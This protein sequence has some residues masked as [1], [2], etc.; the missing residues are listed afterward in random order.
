MEAEKQ[1]NEIGG[2]TPIF[3]RSHGQRVADYAH[4]LADCVSI[5]ANEFAEKAWVSPSTARHHLNNLYDQGVAGRFQAGRE[6]RYWSFSTGLRPDLGLNGNV[7]AI[8][9]RITEGDVERAIMQPGGIVGK[10]LASIIEREVEQ[11]ELVYRL[12][13]QLEFTETV[14]R[15]FLHKLWGPAYEN[16]LDHV[17]IHP[18]NMKLIVF[19]KNS[20]VS[21]AEM[22]KEYASSIVDFDGQVTFEDKRPADINIETGDFKDRKSDA[23]IEASFK[24]RFNA[25][26]QNIKPVF[27]P[28]WNMKVKSRNKT[29]FQLLAIDGLAGKPLE[30]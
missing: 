3:N 6:Q 13:I 1:N 2:L 9:N 17:Y 11:A 21:L 27:L 10:L 24:Q 23:I 19:S 18:G 29:G 26:P 7:S 12:V 8:V 20:G 16:R 25:A 22:P 4:L 28:A 30:W 15:S 14:K 5:S